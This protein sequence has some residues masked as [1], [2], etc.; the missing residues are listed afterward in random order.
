MKRIMKRVLPLVLAFMTIISV[1]SVQS[2]YAEGEELLFDKTSVMEDLTSSTIN[3][4]AFNPSNFPGSDA[5]DVTVINFAEYCYSVYADKLDN[6]GVYVYVYNPADRQISFAS[7]ENQITMRMSTSDYV[8]YGLKFLSKSTGPYENKFIKFKVE[9]PEGLIKQKPFVNNNERLY[10]ISEI[11]LMCIGSNNATSFEVGSKYTYSGYSKGYGPDANSE[12]TL[13]CSMSGLVTLPLEVKSTFYRTGETNGK[14]AYT[15]DSLHSVYF[16]VPNDYIEEFGE[17]YAVH[18]TW[19]NATLKPML[20]IS[21]PEVYAEILPYLGVE[22]SKDT[23]LDYNVIGAYKYRSGGLNPYNDRMEIGF[24]Y[25]FWSDDYEADIYM[26]QY[27]WDIKCNPLYYMF[28]C[29]TENYVVQSETILKA[30]RDTK[31]SFGSSYVKDR[32]SSAVFESVDKEI[33]EVNLSRI[34]SMPLETK[35]LGNFTFNLSNAESE[36]KNVSCIQKVDYLTNQTFDCE[37]YYISES[38]Y[39]DFKAYYEEK[40]SDNTIYLFRYMVSDYTSQ[41]AMINKRNEDRTDFKEVGENAY[42]F[43]QVM[44]L[45]FDVIDVTFELDGVYT[46]IPV[47]MSPIDIIHDATPPPASAPKPNLTWLWIALGIAG[48]CLVCAII[49]VAVKNK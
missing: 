23:S 15:Q 14:S 9:L 19:L 12:S 22:L 4:Q 17:M 29:S 21:N 37:K 11:E 43:Q 13:S 34:D 42:F 3:G 2:V 40:S 48:T 35:K 47:V 6:Y 20:A 8:K 33:T 30:L 1:F 31:T 16:A 5:E 44:N 38:D 41:M 45:D 32:Y 18:A 36:F 26:M 46:V 39:E 7:P 25:N 24:N 49:S 10:E 27:G 28:P